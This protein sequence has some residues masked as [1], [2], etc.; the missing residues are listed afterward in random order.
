MSEEP[1]IQPPKFNAMW[2]AVG[3]GVGTAIGVATKS[4][5]LGVGIGTAIGVSLAVTMP[6]MK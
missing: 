5:A 1:K 2:L 4:L 6:R 3:V